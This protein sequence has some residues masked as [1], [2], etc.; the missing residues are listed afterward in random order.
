MK[1]T[2]RNSGFSLV[3]MSTVV[4][5]I[6][7][8]AVLAFAALDV[9]PQRTRLTGG[10][11]EFAAAI[12]SARSHAYGRNHRVVL[13]L[14][15]DTPNLGN[16]IQYWVVVDPW[17]NM[18]ATLRANP[19]WRT[20]SDLIPVAPAPAGSEYPLFDSGHFNPSVRLYDRGFVDA[21]GRVAHKGCTADL[22]SKVG[23]ARGPTDGTSTFPPPFCFVPND[24][25]CTF[26]TNDGAADEPRRG[27]II[28]EPD[29]TVSFTDALGNPSPDGSASISFRPMGGGG[30]DSVQA[31]VI[32]NT[33]IVRTFSAH[34]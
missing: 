1:R 12:S 27:A 16:P 6:A 21:V 26:C 4:G 34:R 33:G 22:K 2:R 17:S 30:S 7:I 19:G 11:L 32:T 24:T 9:L 18:T 28:F 31:V 25:P 23:L 8:L 14:N 15:A 20:L 5:I 10:A 29:G 3:E 13:L